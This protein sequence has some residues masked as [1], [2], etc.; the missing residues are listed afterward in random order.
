MAERERYTLDTSAVIA[1]FTDEAGAD[2]VGALLDAAARGRIEA[3]ASFMTYMASGRV[4]RWPGLLPI[5][6]L[7]PKPLG[8][9][10]RQSDRSASSRVDCG[11]T[12]P[13]KR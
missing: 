5:Q 13:A 4:K 3:Y 10:S 9:N 11:L 1:Y 12:H 8:W 7:P 6:Y 2:R